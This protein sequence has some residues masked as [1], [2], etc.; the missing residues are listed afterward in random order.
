MILL[1]L[2]AFIL[3]IYGVFFVSQFYNIIFHSY[4]PFISSSSKNITKIIKTVKINGDETVYE[5]GCGRARFLRMFEKKYPNLKLV[6]VENLFS[7][8]LTNYLRLKLQGK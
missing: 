5:L 3:L 1:Y 2:L 4:P 7:I 6:G 8:Y